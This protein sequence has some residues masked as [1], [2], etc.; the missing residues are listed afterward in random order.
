M[1]VKNTL[2]R[3]HGNH[4][5]SVSWTS[6]SENIRSYIFCNGK[7]VVGS[8]LTNST[9]RNV[10]LLT[11]VNSTLKYEVHD[12]TENEIPNSTEES[13]LVCPTIAWN[14]VDNAAA[15]KIYHTIFDTGIIESLLLKIPAQ[16]TSRIEIGCPIKLEGRG[17]RWHYFRVES[18]DQFGNESINEII[19]YFAA[20][21]PPTPELTILRNVNS[22]L[23][24]FQIS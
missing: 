13:P 15:Y 16:K 17:G 8:F 6:E 20:D 4:E 14:S 1:L 9:Q 10:T 7:L 23:L 11:R 5:V 19:P 22:G 21:L 24:S 12:L 18:V 3:H 2:I